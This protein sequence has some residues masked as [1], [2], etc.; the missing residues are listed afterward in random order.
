MNASF[1]KALRIFA[2]HQ[3]ILRTQQAIKLGISPR[4]LYTLSNEGT[5]KAI[6]RGLYQLT[7]R[8]PLTN[9]D[10]IQ[11]SKRI[12]KAVICLVSALHFYGLTTQ[13]PHQVSIALPRFSEKP[14]LEHPP[15]WIFWFSEESYSAGI[16]QEEVDDFQVKVYSREKTIADCF[17][18]RNKIGLDLA[19]EALKDYLKLTERNID[20]LLYFARIDRVEPLMQ[21]YLEALL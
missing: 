13:V 2:A 17:K 5:I 8:E 9:P 14:R 19:L 15:L 18:F 4:V 3:G 20:Q 21:K 12:P 11:V 7:S 16:S 10:L 6:N 1:E